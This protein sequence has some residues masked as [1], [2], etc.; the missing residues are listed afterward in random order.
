LL[1]TALRNVQA[2]LSSPRRTPRRQYNYGHGVDAAS[3]WRL[4]CA[5]ASSLGL[6]SPSAVTT[7]LVYFD[8]ALLLGLALISTSLVTIYFSSAKWNPVLV[9]YLFTCAGFVFILPSLLLKVC[10][11]IIYC[12]SYTL[13]VFG[14]W[15]RLPDPPY[16]PCLVQTA[17]IYAA[18]P[19]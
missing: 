14:G 18:P 2:Q 15:Q 13:L 7:F 4:S 5:S 19:L 8:V 17:L 9:N 3:T 11:G 10:Q 6:T 12:V 1:H 16:V